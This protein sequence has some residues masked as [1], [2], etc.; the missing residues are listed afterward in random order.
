MNAENGVV[1]FE[2]RDDGNCFSKPNDSTGNADSKTFAKL[3]SLQCQGE[4]DD[5]ECFKNNLLV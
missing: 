3:N 5:E 4:L 1:Y 2:V